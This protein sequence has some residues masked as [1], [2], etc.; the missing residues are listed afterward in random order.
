MSKAKTF[1]RMAGMILAW[2]VY[3]TVSKLMVDATGSAYAAG[4]LLRSFALVF[5]TVQLLADGS[6]RRLFHQG[7]ALFLLLLIGVFGFLLDL[8]ANLGYAGGSLSTGTAL[9]KTDVLMVNLVTVLV[10]RQRLYAS[11]WLGTGIMLLGV[12]LVLG[13]DFEGLRFSPT[14]LFFLVSAAC[15]TVNAFLIKRAQN[16]YHEDA[17]M[18]SYYN[19]LVVLVLFAVSTLARGDLR[20][21]DTSALKGFWPL[22]ALGGLAQTCI[23]FFYYRNLKTHAVWVV[24]LWLLL[25]PV[26]SC[27]LGV[28]FL[29]ERLTLLKL[30]GIAVVLAGAGLILLRS[31][32]HKN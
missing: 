19:N 5:L 16:R 22:A 26:V 18:I 23:Y 1:G 3:Y 30:V 10:C 27:F 25:M 20:D 17:D 31:R 7:R 24:K 9:L 4:F 12:L 29:R 32:L 13:V 2:S 11:D 6:F 28:V 21:L 14:D 15:V 8:F